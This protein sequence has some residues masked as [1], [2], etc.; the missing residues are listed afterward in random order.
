MFEKIKAW[1][2]R[3]RETAR[4][5]QA[6]DRL[7]KHI[8][9]ALGFEL[10]EWQRLY[11]ITGI[12]QPPEGRLHGRTTAY[13]LRLLL[14]QSK[15]LLLYEF[16]QVAAYADNPFM[17]RQYQPVPMQYAG[18]FRHEIR[19]TQLKIGNDIAYANY[20][21]D[22][23]VNEDYS[24]AAVLGELKAQGKEGD[25]SVTVCVTT[26]YS[27]IDKGIFLKLSNKNL[28]VKKNKKRNYKK[29]QRQ[30]KRVAAGESIDKRP[31]EIDTRE[32]FGNW[33]MDSVLGKRGKSKNTLLVL[34]ERKTRNEIIFKLPDHTDEAVVAA[35]DRLERKWGADMFK[36]V[37][38]TITV[39]NGSEFADAEGLQ[40]SIIN[41]GEKRT[42]VYYCH[43]YSSWE[44]GTNE[45]TNKMIRRKIPKGTNFD[46]RTEEEVESIENWI[47]GYPRKI[48]GYHSAG[49]LFEEEV[50]QLA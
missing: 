44:R 23:I 15:P 28:P 20:I 21:E 39:D 1:I 35:L 19:G 8:E 29:V 49:E 47:N 30:Q 16:S 11:I 22:K 10:Y 6:A 31:K 48:H 50:K 36:R 45:V 2:K 46:D 9:Q 27:Y 25:F 42:K 5:Q 24:P 34:T 38:K 18:W 17:G 3:K 40:R 7:I 12:W 14:D 4:E 32:E 37:F 41:E 43:P 26:L 33:E 13:I